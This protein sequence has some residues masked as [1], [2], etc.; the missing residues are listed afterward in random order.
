MNF[1]LRYSASL[2]LLVSALFLLNASTAF[3][4]D[5]TW[6]NDTTGTS[7]S[8]LTWYSIT[9][10]SDGT[11]LA[12]AETNFSAGDIWTSTDSGATWTNKTAGTPASGKFWQ[13]ITSS[14]D[15]TKLA[16]FGSGF[17][18]TST[19][20]GATWT[21]HTAPGGG[22]WVIASSQDGTKLVAG[23]IGG[24]IWTS[25]DSGVT[26][27][28]RT[29]GTP[30][31]GQNWIN[32]CSSADGTTLAASVHYNL[33]SGDI[34]T[35]T[36]SGVTWTDRT[37][38]GAFHNSNWYGLACS[39][40]GTKL[41]VTQGAPLDQGGVG[42]GDI[43]TSAD[44]GATLINRTMGT[45]A[46]D[47]E[48]RG[49]ASSPDG[50][51]L[52]AEVFGG[53]IWTSTDSGATWTNET[54]GTSASG[55]QWRAITSSSDGIKLAAEVFGGD[56]WTG[57]IPPPAPPSP[58]PVVAS[59]GGGGWSGGCSTYPQGDLPSWGVIPCTPTNPS[60]GSAVLPA[61]ISPA[62][63]SRAPA[64]A[65][66]AS[67]TPSQFA[68]S[69]L[70]FPQNRQLWSE[71]PDI[72]TLQKFLNTHGYVLTPSGVGAPGNEIT[73]FGMLTYQAL[74]KFQKANNLPATGYLG[75]L[76]RAALANL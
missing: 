56:I 37:A 34:W 14:S 54:T 44:G 38:S 41:A 18:W 30:A 71:G 53:D 29:T 31:N 45:P 13:F 12:A 7:A 23:V 35:S 39:A 69:S 57:I 28:N 46:S 52:A 8:G 19:D 42:T 11:K 36:D 61:S 70:S 47:H 62:P 1:F 50:T 25:T 64:T 55:Q 4:S 72:L 66:V 16:A 21:K 65:Q 10:S 63:L 74:I 9:S 60:Q 32:I 73:T 2:A 27:V 33:P 17:I 76:T 3:A 24:D 26:W 5:F 22:A 49:I 51:K 6:T 58:A 20:S 15:G 68:T 43:V 67:S 59:S 75:P 48:W 40:A